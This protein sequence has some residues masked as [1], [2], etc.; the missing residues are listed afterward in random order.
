MAF[1]ATLYDEVRERADLAEYAEA[2]LE[3]RTRRADGSPETC[4]CPAC[5]SGTGPNGTA[6][7]SLNPHDRMHWRCFA[8]GAGGDV[9]DLAGAVMGTTDLKAELEAVADWAGLDLEGIEKPDLS[10]RMGLAYARARRDMERA[11]R[12]RRQAEA[13]AV[14]RKAE[15]ERVRTYRADAG[16]PRAVEY[17]AARGIDLETARKWGL[18]YDATARRIVI[19]Y[20]GSE[21]YHADRAT[22]EGATPR[23]KKPDSGLVGHEPI[24]NPAALESPGFAVCE[25]QLDALAISDAGFPAVACGG[26]G[27]NRLLRELERR[28]YAGRISIDFDNDPA[29]RL[30]AAKAAEKLAAIGCEHTV[31]TGWPEGVKDPFEWW[32]LDRHGLAEAIAESLGGR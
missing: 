16:N 31:L 15:A 30:A 23:Y 18:G 2:H 10:T 12:E 21:W 13:W 3:V 26:T 29:G 22:D 14:A 1:K 32:R 7:L 19:P 27:F 11:E 20:P 4:V 6:A 5:G 28:S 17:L 9:Y 25:G 24:W 8:C